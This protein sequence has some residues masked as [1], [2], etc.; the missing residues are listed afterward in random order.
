MDAKY[1]RTLL[2]GYLSYLCQSIVNNLLPL[3][4][5]TFRKDF[6]FTLGQLSFLITI[7]FVIQIFIDALSAPFIRK[8]GYKK[9]ILFAHAIIVIGLSFLGILPFIMDPYAGILISIFFYAIGSAILEVVASPMIEALPTTNKSGK[10][11]LLHSFY[12]WGHV[13]IILLS[14]GYF[15]LFGVEHWRFLPFFWAIFPLFNFFLLLSSPIITL[16]GD[17]HPT[18]Y[19]EIFKS[20]VFWILFILMI[21]AGASEQAMAQWSSYFAESALKVSKTMGD[22]LGPCMFAF[23]MGLSRASYGFL[24]RYISLQKYIAISATLCIVSYLLVVFSPIPILALVGCGLC[25]LSVAIM[26]PGVYSLG[27][28]HYAKGGSALFALLAIGGDIGCT[29]GPGLA[30]IVATALG[31]NLKA[32]FAFT[33]LFPI[34]ILILINVLKHKKPTA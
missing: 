7:N 27:S 11:S 30:G 4:F 21:C 18:P 26:W 28:M 22:L 25:G 32:G 20:S 29:S 6:S 33:C 1:K 14:T 12:C 24:S 19:R 34:L 5:V 23:F 31:D 8:I 15:L 13:L 17:A 16:P 2:G 10:M 3:F 9:A